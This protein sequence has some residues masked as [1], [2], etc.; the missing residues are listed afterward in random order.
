MPSIP[1]IKEEM[2]RYVDLEKY[3]KHERKHPFYEEMLADI[4]FEIKKRL[5]K[6]KIIRILELG[7]GTGIVT[8]ELAKLPFVK[9]TAVEIDTHCYE[10]L[11]KNLSECKNVDVI[12]GDVVNFQA[13]K[14]SDIV[15]SVFS[16][17]HIQY[18]RQY[19]LAR[20]INKNL[21]LHGIYIMGNELIPKFKSEPERKKSLKLYHN[22]IIEKALQE[23]H[24]EV[25]EIEKKALYSGLHKIGDFK[26]HEKILEEGMENAGFKVIK[27]NKIGPKNEKVG[28][29]FVYVFEKT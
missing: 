5:K 24:K 10:L 9:I 4:L 22:F 13:S 6:D 25:A 1:Q 19:E 29:V 16:H 20:N 18:N 23:G 8:L 28:G 14:L 26:F 2:S 15:V 12:Q 3:H 21:R 7:A 27:K 17:D 11:K